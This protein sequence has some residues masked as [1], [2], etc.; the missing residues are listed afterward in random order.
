MFRLTEPR[1]QELLNMFS[2]FLHSAHFVG[3]DHITN[4]KH[5]H[6]ARSE[7]TVLCSIAT[8]TSCNI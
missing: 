8:V 5:Q 4:H 1:P 6:H 7:D 3:S 2:Q